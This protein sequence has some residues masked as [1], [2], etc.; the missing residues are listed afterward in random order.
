MNKNVG[1]TPFVGRVLLIAANSQ[2]N[3]L[4]LP[5]PFGYLW[6]WLWNIGELYLLSFFGD[7]FH[8]HWVVQYCQEA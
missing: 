7:T 6:K 4:N 3:H 2:G 5:P 8:I 1:C